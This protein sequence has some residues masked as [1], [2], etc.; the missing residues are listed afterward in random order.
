MYAQTWQDSLG[1]SH[2]TRVINITQFELCGK[3]SFAGC[4]VRADEFKLLTVGN[5]WC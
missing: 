3:G 2:E 5:C 4:F 1:G